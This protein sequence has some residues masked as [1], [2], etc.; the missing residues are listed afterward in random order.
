[1]CGPTGRSWGLGDQ[2]K[3]PSFG[4]TLERLNI[5]EC[6]V[7][8][9]SLQPPFF[10]LR[11]A[12]IEFSIREKKNVRDQTIWY[13]QTLVQ[14]PS[15]AFPTQV[16][17]SHRIPKRE[18]IAVEVGGTEQEGMRRTFLTKAGK[19]RITAFVANGVI[20]P[21]VKGSVSSTSSML[22]LRFAFE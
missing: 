9:L 15:S 17:S 14:Q 8:L 2:V 12:S 22:F 7:K 21:L 13:E 4:T 20:G 6:I 1:M 11:P 10:S 3:S 16:L 5:H 19:S 18:G